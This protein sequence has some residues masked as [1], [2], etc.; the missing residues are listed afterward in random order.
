MFDGPPPYRQHAAED[1]LSI[2]STRLSS[3]LEGQTD[4]A[5]TP[6]SFS[7]S[8]VRGGG[9]NMKTS[10]DDC[11][12][13]A[14]IGGVVIDSDNDAGSRNNSNRRNSFVESNRSNSRRSL[15]SVDGGGGGKSKSSPAASES[16]VS[17]VSSSWLNSPESE[18]A[19]ECQRHLERLHLRRR[20]CETL[21]S[22][23]RCRAVVN[24]LYHTGLPFRPRV[25]CVSNPFWRKGFIPDYSKITK[26]T[27]ENI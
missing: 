5:P 21:E 1:R 20:I 24:P 27:G 6:P 9:N 7:G 22:W 18:S 17:S 26:K 23:D 16:S 4:D 19:L 8:G 2:L 15:G 12:L 3:I 14:R 13:A 11:G 25:V 10:S